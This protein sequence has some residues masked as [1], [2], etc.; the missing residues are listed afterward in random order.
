MLHAELSGTPYNKAERRR[1][2]LPLLNDRSEQSI[3]FK[4]ANIS[5]ILIEL[6]RPY[7]SG[8]KPRSNYQELLL[9]V[10]FDRLNENPAIQ[11]LVATDS[12]RAATAP[13]V[14]DILKALT[15]PPKPVPHQVDE[16]KSL[17]DQ[18]HGISAFIADDE[19]PNL[20]GQLN[21]HVVEIGAAR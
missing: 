2:L 6:G 7:I 16:V 14:D 15:D 8:Y 12:E 20:V 1:Q 3:E 10:V 17:G 9:E 19:R 13:S 4:H 11:R 5:A 21:S 18:P